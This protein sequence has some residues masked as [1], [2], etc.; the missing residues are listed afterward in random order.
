MPLLIRVGVA[1]L[2]IALLAAAVPRP[3]SRRGRRP[4][5]IRTAA[6]PLVALA[7]L[8]AL[9][10]PGARRSEILRR[11]SGDGAARRGMTLAGGGCWVIAVTVMAAERR[12]RH[13]EPD[14]VGPSGGGASGFLDSLAG[15]RAALG[16]IAGA[17]CLA[18]LP[19]LG[20]AAAGAALVVATGA[21]R[22]P[23]AVVLAA[24]RRAEAAAERSMPE[25]LELLAACCRSGYPLEAALSITA[26]HTPQPL[27]GVLE[28]ARRRQEAGEAPAAALRVEA[29]IV[30]IDEVVAVGRLVA[31]QHELGLPLEAPLLARAEAARARAHTAAL[32][33]AGRG[34]PLASL[35]TA[36]VVAPCCV[37]TLALWVL[38]ATVTRSGFA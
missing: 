10:T 32:L 22:L 19:M 24:G 28:R 14:P 20:M 38:S 34:V 6:R 21:S 35:I 3:R 8:A 27:G 2:G 33:R 4:P 31:R 13:G 30:G 9:L 25:A 26:A 7:A 5:G 29:E 17:A 23:D 12:H 1:G 18:T 16:L 15:V 11:S 36:I 37:G